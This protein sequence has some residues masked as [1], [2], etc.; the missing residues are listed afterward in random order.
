M[1]EIIKEFVKEELIL[2]DIQRE[3]V[4]ASERIC[5][6]FD[7]ILRGYPI[8]NFLIWKLK[9]E[10][11]INKKIRF[12][13]FLDNYDEYS[14]AHNIRKFDIEPKTTYYAILD[15]QQRTQSILIALK[16]FLNLRKYRG[17]KDD[18]NEYE[19]NFLYINL[20]GEENI[21]EDYKYEF[22]FLTEKMAKLE[23]D[24]NLRKILL[25]VLFYIY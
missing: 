11:I 7:S 10:D 2:P 24:L 17:K 5:R 15:G 8:G 1:S 4:W 14:P 20:L 22:Q 6:L 16:G 12:Y 21:E 25:C 19:K 13:K 3:F 18:P 23:K 9:G